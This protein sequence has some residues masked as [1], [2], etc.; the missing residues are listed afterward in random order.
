MMGKFTLI[1]TSKGVLTGKLLHFEHW[2]FSILNKPTFQGF[3]GLSVGLH[4]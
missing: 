1:Q 4:G 2:R 3:I